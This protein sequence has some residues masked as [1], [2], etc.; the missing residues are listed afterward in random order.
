MAAVLEIGSIRER[1]PL[2]WMNFM[3]N[4]TVQEVLN[5]ETCSINDAQMFFSSGQTGKKNGVN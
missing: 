2:K 4:T 5:I 3:E 1:F